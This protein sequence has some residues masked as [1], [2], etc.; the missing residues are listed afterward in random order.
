MG[1]LE[2]TVPLCKITFMNN[3]VNV[4]E[5]SFYSFTAAHLQ[6]PPVLQQQLNA[7]ALAQAAAQA[8]Q[9]AAAGATQ[10]LPMPR[11]QELRLQQLQ[12]ERERLKLRQQEIMKQVKTQHDYNKKSV[13][14]D[15]T[16]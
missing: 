12:L 8:S 9:L 16:H 3:F 5:F 11:Q 15:F 2:P 14:S 7:A 10:L 13:Y 6:R 4:L 1:K